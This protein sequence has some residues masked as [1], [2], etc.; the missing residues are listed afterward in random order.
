MEHLLS[1]RL[2]T[3][4]CGKHLRQGSHSQGVFRS[5]QERKHEHRSTLSWLGDQLP[6]WKEQQEK[7][8]KQIIFIYLVCEDLEVLSCAIFVT[9]FLNINFYWSRIDLQCVSFCC[10]ANSSIIHTYI[11]LLFKIASPYRSLQY[12]IV[13]LCYTAGSH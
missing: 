3:A 2:R 9:V 12:R 4:F 7:R 1:N 5:S 8:R 13:F 11:S 6:R 10:T